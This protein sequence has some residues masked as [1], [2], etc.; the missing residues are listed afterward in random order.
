MIQQRASKS[1]TAHRQPKKEP[2]DDD[3]DGSA[4][5]SQA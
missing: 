5:Y 2:M 4:N 1:M 3:D